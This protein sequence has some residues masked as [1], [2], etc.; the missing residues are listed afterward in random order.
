MPHFILEYAG[1][2][3]YSD[4]WFQVPV[5][6]D[7]EGSGN[8]EAIAATHMEIYIEFLAATHLNPAILWPFGYWSRV[9]ELPVSVSCLSASLL[10]SASQI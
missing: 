3:L 1:F 4:T 7:P 5:N 8:K 2:I 10:L 9:W 6:L